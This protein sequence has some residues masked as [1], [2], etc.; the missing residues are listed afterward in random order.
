MDGDG[1]T[2]PEESIFRLVPICVEPRQA[3]L[4]EALAYS[5]DSIDVAYSLLIRLTSQ[6]EANDIDLN[7]VV[8]VQLFNNA[9]SMVDALHN[10]RQILS[11]LN[12]GGP[13]A[14]EFL[15]RYRSATDLRNA[16]D[17]LKDQA[18]NLA[19][20]KKAEPPLIGALSYNYCTD[21]AIVKDDNG[22]ILE[23]TKGTSIVISIG[24][25][26][27]K[28]QMEFLNPASMG[29]IHGNI[30]GLQLEAFGYSINL[31]EAHRDFA[32]LVSRMNEVLARDISD[33]ARALADEN[34]V[35][36][37]DL[38]GHFGAGFSAFVKWTASP[39]ADV[40]SASDTASP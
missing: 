5:A 18:R 8:R 29:V 31:M 3:L 24:R 14:S 33:K 4:F 12:F 15:S 32:Q 19:M 2:L 6:A 36:Y 38:M 37:E 27:K 30:A 20:K 10:M 23:I 34:G 7:R 26:R 22:M 39:S 35:P 13:L 21:E 11:A 16:M 28:A 17:H 9:W 25:L 40:A 1:M